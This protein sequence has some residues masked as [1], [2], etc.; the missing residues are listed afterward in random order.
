MT[1]V[2]TMI[3]GEKMTKRN[4]YEYEVKATIKVEL[5][6]TARDKDDALDKIQELLDDKECSSFKVRQWW[7]DVLERADEANKS[8]EAKIK[9]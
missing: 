5:K 3:R 9:Q 8:R 6:V 7:Y 2:V 4:E 1:A